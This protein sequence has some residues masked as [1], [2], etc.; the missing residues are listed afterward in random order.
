[1]KTAVKKPTLEWMGFLCQWIGAEGVGEE[2][3]RREVTLANF[4]ALY[5]PN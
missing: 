3:R 2:E 5:S 4:M 1:M